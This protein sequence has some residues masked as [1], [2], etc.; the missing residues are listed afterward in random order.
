MRLLRSRPKYVTEFHRQ[1]RSYR[2]MREASD[3]KC[4]RDAF[5]NEV[6]LV[7][8]QILLWLKWVDIIWRGLIGC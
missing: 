5:W 1:G 7:D 2:S 4:V 3:W 6:E 8:V